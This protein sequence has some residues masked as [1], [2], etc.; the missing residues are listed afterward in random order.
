MSD[1]ILDQGTV[2][3]RLISRAGIREPRSIRIRRFSKIPKDP[4]E[5][6]SEKEK[7]RT[8]GAISRVSGKRNPGFLELNQ[9]SISSW[10]LPASFFSS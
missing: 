3:D 9:K 7:F 2:G 4:A 5:R 6:R 8:T 10:I 1:E